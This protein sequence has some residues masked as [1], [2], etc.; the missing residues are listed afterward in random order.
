MNHLGRAAKVVVT[1][2]NTT[3]VEGAGDSANIDA[4]VNQIRAQME[5]TTSDFDKEKLQE[6]LS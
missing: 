2:E 6:R 5:E 1:K 4:R 3:I